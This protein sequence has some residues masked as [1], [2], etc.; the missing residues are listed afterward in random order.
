MSKVELPQISRRS[1]TTG[2][3]AD[4]RTPVGL[5]HGRVDPADVAAFKSA[6]EI[7]RRHAKGFLFASHFLPKARRDAACAVV[8][9]FHMMDEALGGE[10]VPLDTAAALREQPAI[11]SPRYRA[12]QIDARATTDGTSCTSCGSNESDTRLAL[13]RDRLDEI[14]SGRLELPAPP[15]RSE[16]QHALHAFSLAAARFDV[17]QHYFLTLAE[18]QRIDRT[19]TRYAT[20]RALEKQCHQIAGVK[21]MILTA[22][23]GATHSDAGRL[24]ARMGV[25]VRLTHLLRDIKSDQDRGRVYLPQEDLV[26]FR[27]SENDLAR[28]VINDPFRALMRF[29]IDRARRLYRE[30]AEG[31]AWLSGDA[32]RLTAATIGVTEAG[33]LT[34]IER[35]RYDVF[36]ARRQ[37]GTAQSLRRLPAALRLARRRDGQAIPNV[38]R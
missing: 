10:D 11:A 17:P 20:W 35:S 37:P 6:R 21:G 28:S 23:F 2:P 19:V 18:G 27:Y 12:A 4:G 26:R 33:I 32:A 7:C 16:Q 13:F 24:A 3:L 30:S 25:A 38:F 31:I 1:H 5:S 8:A 34:A 14:Y 22:I 9:F 36:S 15:S 29:Q